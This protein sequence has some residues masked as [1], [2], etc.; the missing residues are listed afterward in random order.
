MSSTGLQA[1]P[2][3]HQAEGW[4]TQVEELLVEAL[5]RVF[6]APRCPGALAQAEDLE[7][8]PRVA[9]VGGVE[10]GP[11]R[12]AAGS[13]A[14]EMG[15]LFEA[16]GGLLHRHLT[17]VQADR[18]GQAGDADQGLDGDARFE[19]RIVAPKALFD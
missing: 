13:G 18:D 2:R 7:L 14:L 19:A 16:A 12:L 5:V 17:G 3:C 4:C 10:G 15:V 6:G 9:A 11:G 1:E 8:A